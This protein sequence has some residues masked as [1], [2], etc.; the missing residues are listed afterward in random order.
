MKWFKVRL[1]NQLSISKSS[2]DFLSKFDEPELQRLDKLIDD[3][4][5]KKHKL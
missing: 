3:C 4:E 2:L 5:R 1:K